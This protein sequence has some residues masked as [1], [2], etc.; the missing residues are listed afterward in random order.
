[1]AGVLINLCEERDCLWE[2]H[3]V[4]QEFM[5][6]CE[7]LNPCLY[8]EENEQLI[9]GKFNFLFRCIFLGGN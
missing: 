2:V 1:M 4:N 9:V 5:T 8:D 3:E 7:L 6:N